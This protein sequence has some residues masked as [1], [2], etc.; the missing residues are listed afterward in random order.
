[1]SILQIYA[2]L[3]AANCRSKFHRILQ[4]HMAENHNFCSRGQTFGLRSNLRPHMWKM[5]TSQIFFVFFTIW[6][7]EVFDQQSWKSTFENWKSWDKNIFRVRLEPPR[8]KKSQKCVPFDK[9]QPKPKAKAKLKAKALAEVVYII[10]PRLV[11]SHPVPHKVSTAST[12]S[13]I[14][15]KFSGEASPNKWTRLGRKKFTPLR[16]KTIFR[17]KRRENHPKIGKNSNKSDLAQ[18]FKVSQH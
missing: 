12:I 8:Q 17:Q 10:T 5:I 1:M 18:T 4:G 15:L 3:H 14:E 16:L 9:P 7:G 11:P 2:A 13:L 6:F